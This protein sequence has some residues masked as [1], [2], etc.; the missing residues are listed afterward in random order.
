MYFSPV[1]LP[2]LLKPL[3][4]LDPGSGSLLIQLAVAAVLGLGVLIRLQWGRIKKLLGGKS[5]ETDTE[6][7]DDNEYED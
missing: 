4:Y 2:Q 6:D 3:A 7:D 1:L 5:A